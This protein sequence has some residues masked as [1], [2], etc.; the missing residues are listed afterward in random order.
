[1]QVR[2]GS[3]YGN[4]IEAALKQPYMDKIA[5]A[6]SREI[7][8]DHTV[9]DVISGLPELPAGIGYSDEDLVK[10]LTLAASR[11][12]AVGDGSADAVKKAVAGLK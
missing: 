2:R 4:V 9:E 12:V 5:Q 11:G 8:P 1:M 3:G 7:G 10:I 6:I